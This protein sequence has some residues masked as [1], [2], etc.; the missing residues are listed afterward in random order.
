MLEEIEPRRV[1][2]DCFVSWYSN[3][4]SVPWNPVGHTVLAEHKGQVVATHEVMGGRY[5]TVV[6]RRHYRGIPTGSARSRQTIHARQL[7]PEVEVRPL[8]VYERVVMAI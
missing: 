7:A 8:E 1:S 5:R 4:Y 6:D 3:R 2:L